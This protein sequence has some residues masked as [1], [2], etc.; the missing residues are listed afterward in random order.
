MNTRAVDVVNT[1]P[2]P[3]P[4]VR[5]V[6]GQSRSDVVGARQRKRGC[7]RTQSLEFYGSSTWARTRDRRTNRRAFYNF[8]LSQEVP[9]PYSD[10]QLRPI[11]CPESCRSVSDDLARNGNKQ[12][13]CRAAKAGP[14]ADRLKRWVR[15]LI[16]QQTRQVR[17][18]CGHRCSTSS[19][20][21]PLRDWSLLKKG[22]FR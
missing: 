17:R 10:Q 11:F 19:W 2:W 4:A 14:P 15:Q 3:A 22:R 16:R 7:A 18:R 13:R 21:H 9:E 1:A 20:L 12:A 5:A 8:R 6:A